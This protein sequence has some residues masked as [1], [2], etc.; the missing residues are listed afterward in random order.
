M[1][2][3]QNHAV[4]YR[5]FDLPANFPVI[6]LLG[7]TWISR[8]EPIRRIHFH[9]CLEIGF[10]YEGKGL[11]YIDGETVP[12]E[13]PC[14]TLIPQNM[15]HFSRAAEDSICYWNWLYIDPVQLLPDKDPQIAGAMDRFF[16]TLSAAGCV[17]P[18]NRH[19]QVYDLTRMIVRELGSSLSYRREIVRELFGALLFFLLRQGGPAVSRPSARRSMTSIE[20]AI[21]Y[22]AENYMN[23]MSVGMLA[24]LCHVSVSHFRRLFKQVLGWAPQEYIQIVRID[25][26]CAMLYNRDC[27][28]TEVSSSVGYP[29]PSSFN[30]QFQRIYHMSPS[31]WRRKIC[32]EENPVVTAYFNALPSTTMEFF[33]KEYDSPGQTPRER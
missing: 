12:V 27:S 7:D 14:V 17:Y 28:V 31:Q 33:P 23:E 1:S 6:A 26:A 13:A 16:K 2:G 3:E 29:S 4:F 21:S 18:A 25:R 9:N 20:P 32:S 8:P 11:F 10:L 30:R 15:P 5:H 22:I 19:P 24:G